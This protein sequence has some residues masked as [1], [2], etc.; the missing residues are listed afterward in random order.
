APPAAATPALPAPEDACIAEQWRIARGELGGARQTITGLRGRSQGD[1]VPDE[2]TVCAVLLDA[3]LAV[4][5]RQPD[6]IRFVERADSV[7]RAGPVGD[8]MRA[9]AT[10]AL[11]RLYRAL[12]EREAALEAVRRRPYMRGWPHYLSSY[13]REEGRLAA[14]EGERAAAARACEQYLALR[15]APDAELA[16]QVDSVKGELARVNRRRGR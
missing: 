10:L 16:S 5:E 8:E 2:A 6:A 1:E 11:T 3:M 15:S 12:G 7:L 9:Y 14:Q 13:L 4:S